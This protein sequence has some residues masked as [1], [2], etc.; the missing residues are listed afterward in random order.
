MIPGAGGGAGG[1]VT[2]GDIKVNFPPLPQPNNSPITIK[3]PEAAYPTVVADPSK[4]KPIVV[5]PELVYPH[6][7]KRMIVH[8]ENPLQ[9]YYKAMAM[10]MNPYYAKMAVENPYYGEAVAK[11]RGFQNF[12]SNPS[13]SAGMMR[14][15]QFGI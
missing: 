7:V 2:L 13:V 12:L 3:T 4:Q 10:Q 8:H 6:K 14:L 11:S 9:N 5:V 15:P 1:G